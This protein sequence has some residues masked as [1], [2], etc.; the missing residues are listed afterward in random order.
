MT[1]DDDEVSAER[2]AE[3][4]A[5]GRQ[6]AGKLAWH[7]RDA[8]RFWRDDLP[9]LIDAYREK[10]QHDAEQDADADAG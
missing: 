9:K 5:L 10:L 3:I 6:V 8:L 1:D 2:L 7:E 4:A